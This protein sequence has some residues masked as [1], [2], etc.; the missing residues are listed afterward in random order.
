MGVIVYSMQ[1]WKKVETNTL[2][3]VIKIRYDQFGE[4]IVNLIKIDPK[5]LC[6]DVIVPM[7][8]FK[9]DYTLYIA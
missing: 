2:Y 9:E 1:I 5:V 3:K 8:N 6:E 4:Q 7:C